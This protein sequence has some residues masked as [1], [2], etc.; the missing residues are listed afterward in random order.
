MTF[1][2]GGISYM[3]VQKCKS[4]L[5]FGH[6]NKAECSKLNKSLFSVSECIATKC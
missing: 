3:Y 5:K 6:R 1:V 2:T 4:I